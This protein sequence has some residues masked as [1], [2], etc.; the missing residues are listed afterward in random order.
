M[1]LTTRRPF[2]PVADIRGIRILLAIAAY[3][4]YEI[5]QMD[6]KT[7]FLNCRLDEDIYMAQHEGTSTK[8]AF[9]HTWSILNGHTV[10][11]VCD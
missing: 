3:Y 7:A 10:T 11:F 5:W 8:M 2:S 9:R 1:D 4:D 6:V